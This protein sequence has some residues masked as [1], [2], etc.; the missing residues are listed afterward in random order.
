MAGDAVSAGLTA[1]ERLI[2]Q[3]HYSDGWTFEAIADG[4]G[5]TSSTVRSQ[6]S[7]ALEKLFRCIPAGCDRKSWTKLHLN[8]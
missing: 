6:H 4:V 5:V 2:I 1:R 7:T 3:L 8:L